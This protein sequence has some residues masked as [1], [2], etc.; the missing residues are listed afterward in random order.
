MY[1]LHIEFDG[2][3]SQIDYLVLTKKFTLIIECK[4][5]LKQVRFRISK[6][7]YIFQVFKLVSCANCGGNRSYT[8]LSYSNIFSRLSN[9]NFFPLSLKQTISYSVPL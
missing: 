7:M 3:T 4:R 5:Y 6:D 8:V 1:D 9:K 2:L